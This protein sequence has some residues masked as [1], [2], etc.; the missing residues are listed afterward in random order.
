[1][2]VYDRVDQGEVI[3]QSQSKSV[4][5]IVYWVTHRHLNSIHF[6]LCFFSLSLPRGCVHDK[7]PTRLRKSSSGPF[8]GLPSQMINIRTKCSREAQC[9]L[10]Y[11]CLDRVLNYHRH[12][13]SAVQVCVCVCV[14]DKHAPRIHYYRVCF[15]PL[16][17]H[18]PGRGLALITKCLMFTKKLRA[19][20]DEGLFLRRVRAHGGGLAAR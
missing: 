18:C 3:R 14:L 2:F 11:N 8:N 10:H 17:Q 6:L 13:D 1:M 7:R 9:A 16:R 5:G 15:L 19:A 12:S 20:D 4:M